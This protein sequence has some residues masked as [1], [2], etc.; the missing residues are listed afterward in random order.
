MREAGLP[1]QYW[2]SPE[3]LGT[4]RMTCHVWSHFLRSAHQHLLFLDSDMIANRTALSDGLRYRAN[5][6]GLLT[7]Y[8][9]RMHVG[10]PAGEDRLFKR[11]VGNAGT[12][13]TRPLS[14]LVLAE[15][16]DHSF[17]NIDDAYCD[18]LTARG[19][20]IISVN[21]SRL[22]HLGITGLNN[23]YFGELEHGL[24]FRAD[25]ERQLEAIAATYDDL[26][27]RQELFVRSTELKK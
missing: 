26:M 20:P 12:L 11:K 18:F 25:S 19:V 21:R 17:A 13:W 3:Q 2:R 23:R 8:N 15:F 6:E 4:H 22:Q 1:P 7:L 9:S 16:E 10:E 27:H 24:F 14:Q 5:F